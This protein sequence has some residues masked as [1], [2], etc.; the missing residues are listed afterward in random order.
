MLIAQARQAA[1]LTLKISC[2]QGEKNPT[3]SHGPHLMLLP[4]QPAVTTQQAKDHFLMP[5]GVSMGLQLL[6]TLST[7]PHLDPLTSSLLRQVAHANL[8]VPSSV[9]ACRGHIQAPQMQL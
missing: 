1:L 7:T 9:Q 6:L 4:T 3:Q 5:S 2:L 8:L